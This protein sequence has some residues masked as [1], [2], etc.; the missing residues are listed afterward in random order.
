MATFSSLWIGPALSP[1]EQLCIRSFLDHG[2]AFELYTYGSVTDVPEGCAVL[3][4][5]RILGEEH[6]FAYRR[7]KGKGSYGAFANLFR[8]KLLFERG[9]WWVDTDVVCLSRAIADAE[10]QLAREDEKTVG[11]AI[12]KFPAGHSCMEIACMRAMAAG[13]DVRW[14]ETGPTLMS[15]LAK[16]CSLEGFLV[17]TASFYPIHFSEFSSLIR[18]DQCERV[19]RKVAGATFLHLWNEMFRRAQ[20]N[21]HYGPPRGSYLARLF[22]RHEL[23]QRFRLEYVAV[24]HG[25]PQQLDV[26]PVDR[27]L[28]AGRA[29]GAGSDS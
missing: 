8:Y 28:P 14:G 17:P 6:V 29:A 18:P 10:V 3:D 11:N 23:A 25:E 22:V 19:E 16:S 12:L 4:A 13:H 2:H 26:L 20:Y 21:K 7:G 27:T 24:G 5:N 9:G 15:K 1:S